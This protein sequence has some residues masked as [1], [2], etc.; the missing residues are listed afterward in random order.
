MVAQTVFFNFNMNPYFFEDINT[1]YGPNLK[2]LMD[3]DN[4]ETYYVKFLSTFDYDDTYTESS[5]TWTNSF[6]NTS[7]GVLDENHCLNTNSAYDNTK[8]VPISD[9][10][11]NDLQILYTRITGSRGGMLSLSDSSII[12]AQFGDA[13]HNLAAM[14]LCK[15][16]TVNNVGDYVLAYAITHQEVQVTGNF[17]IP[18]VSGTNYG[19]VLTRWGKTIE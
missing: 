15:Q 9:V 6:F 14:L 2:N 5:S 17:Q 7:N 3:A 10:E 19:R 1:V 4:T 18:F 13:V 11:T 8:F 12:E 16:S